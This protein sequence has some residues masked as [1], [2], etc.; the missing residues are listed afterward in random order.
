MKYNELMEG[1]LGEKEEGG[2]PSFI[3]DK[4]S[5]PIFFTDNLTGEKF[6]MERYTVW[7]WDSRKQSHQVVEVGNNLNAL[8]SKYNVE[9]KNIIPFPK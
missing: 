3:M 5:K 6:E 2:T 4:G 7:K 9:D 8:Q 1:L